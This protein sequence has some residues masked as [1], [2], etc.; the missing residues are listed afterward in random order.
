M[1]KKLRALLV[2]TQSGSHRSDGQLERVCT[3]WR[4]LCLNG[5]QTRSCANVGL[6]NT[7]HFASH[8]VAAF[9]NKALGDLLPPSSTERQ[10]LA[11]RH[12]A[13]DGELRR[14]T[15]LMWRMHT[16]IADQG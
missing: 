9:S 6:P 13:V 10:I 1:N 4:V 5:H 14:K 3:I 7:P 2:S 11:A 12:D 8:S 16:G 15:S